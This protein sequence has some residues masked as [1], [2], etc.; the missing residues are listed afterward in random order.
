MT[1]IQQAPVNLMQTGVVQPQGVALAHRTV[2]QP[3]NLIVQQPRPTF[4]QTIQPQ[5]QILR[6]VLVIY[7]KIT[8]QFMVS[9][10]VSASYAADLLIINKILKYFSIISLIKYP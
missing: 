9:R 2:L 8:F 3:H 7:I 4:I 10:Y 6:Q 5:Q 1:G